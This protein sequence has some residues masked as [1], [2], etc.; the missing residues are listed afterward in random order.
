MTYNKPEI[1]KLHNTLDVI[2]GDA[3]VGE[4][5]RDNT[6]PHPHDATFFA[7]ESDE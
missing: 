7:Y 6:Y 3:K 1:L 4:T 5:Y 2:Q